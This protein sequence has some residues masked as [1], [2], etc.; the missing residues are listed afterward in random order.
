MVRRIAGDR[1]ELVV[2]ED[3]YEFSAPEAMEIGVALVDASG[4][5]RFMFAKR[6]LELLYL[7]MESHSLD[8]CRDNLREI[9]QD[10]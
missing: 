6:R 8:Q 10:M 3:R 7:K 2:E 1:I 9:L 5:S 4:L